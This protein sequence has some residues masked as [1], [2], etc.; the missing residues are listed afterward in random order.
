MDPVTHP[1][2]IL[3]SLINQPVHPRTDLPIHS[4]ILLATNHTINL[5]WH[6]PPI[7]SCT[8]PPTNPPNHPIHPYKTAGM[9]HANLTAGFTVGAVERKNYLPH[10]S[11]I[12]EGDV[13]TALQSLPLEPLCLLQP[14]QSLLQPLQSLLQPQYLLLL[15][16]FHS[17]L[18]LL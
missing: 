15:Q 12:R 1:P 7:H 6:Q 10:L 4:P 11:D 8:H 16:P 18:V 9:V 5:S 17:L 13:V 14:L 3:N 2:L